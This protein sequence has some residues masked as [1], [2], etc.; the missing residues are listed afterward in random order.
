MAAGLAPGARRLHGHLADNVLVRGR[1]QRGDAEAALA[2]AAAIA[3]APMP[4]VK[5]TVTG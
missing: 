5:P 3:K 4:A 1:V 2:G